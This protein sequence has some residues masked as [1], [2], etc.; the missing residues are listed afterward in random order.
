M[1]HLKI[2]FIL[3]AHNLCKIGDFD[4]NISNEATLS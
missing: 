3:S 2:T 4:V 1:E